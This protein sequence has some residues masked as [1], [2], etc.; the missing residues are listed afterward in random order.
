MKTPLINEQF[1]VKMTLRH[2]FEFSLSRQFPKMLHKF[3]Q[4]K[5]E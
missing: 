5:D 1:R 3:L 4:F 2:V